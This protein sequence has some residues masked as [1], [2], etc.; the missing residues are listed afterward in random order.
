MKVEEHWPTV[1]IPQYVPSV[2][3][4]QAERH[5]WRHSAELDETYLPFKQA[6]PRATV[7]TG[8]HLLPAAHVTKLEVHGEA[9]SPDAHA[10]CWAAFWMHVMPAF[11][12]EHVD[13]S[14]AT[15]A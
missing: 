6:V 15:E 14:A 12:V 2:R 10:D 4:A 9:P 3:P 1:A 7:C 11:T 8:D 5:F 13:G